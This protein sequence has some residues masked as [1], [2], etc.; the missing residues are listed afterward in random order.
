MAPFA[1]ARIKFCYLAQAALAHLGLCTTLT[2][3]Y[4]QQ[5]MPQLPSPLLRQ[6]LLHA[7]AQY[8]QGTPVM[9]DREFD[10]M[11]QRYQALGG[12]LPQEP[13]VLPSLDAMDLQDWL[14]R[15]DHAQVAPRLFTITPKIDGCALAL[16]Y[17]GGK[18]VQAYT[19]T[20]K[21]A[22]ALARL[23]PTI[24]QHL[25]CSGELRV[26]GELYDHATKKQSTPAA[27]LRRKVPNA[28]GLSF[29]A[30]NVLNPQGMDHSEQLETLER[31]GFQ[32]QPWFFA[33]TAAQVRT[34]HQSWRQGKAWTGLPTDGIV[35]TLD[36]AEA[37]ERLGYATRTPR[38]ALAMKALHQ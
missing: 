33:D 35:V 14:E 9:T 36:C 21:C 16:V 4:T 15:L 23:V 32:V 5:S 8:R 29:T 22:L 19:R 34:L 30:F 31:L 24:P 25:R 18:L 2:P 37:Q 3:R 20:G 7:E 12:T 26:R 10:L 6:Q 27:A 28:Q 11:L 1:Q 13:L 38:F 17:Q